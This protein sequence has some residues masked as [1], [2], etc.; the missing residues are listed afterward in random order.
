MK[1][2]RFSILIP[3]RNRAQTLKFAV[4]SCLAQ[5]FDDYEI[6]I[7]DNHSSPET[8]AVVESFASDK[9]RYER[10]DVPLAMSDNWEL[11]V[12]HARGEFVTI[13]GDDDALMRHAL[14]EANRLIEKH[15]PQLIRWAWAYYKWPD[16]SIR[17]DA[18][19]LSFIFTGQVDRVKSAELASVLLQE[20]KRYHE[21]P[22]IYNSFVHRQL[23]DNLRNRTGR[24]F[25]ALSPDVYSGFAFADLAGRF[26]SVSRPLG[27]CGTS[28]HSTGQA[29]VIGCG[30]SANNIGQQFFASCEQSGLVWN[31]S[32][33]RVVKSISAVIAE[34]YAQYRTVLHGSAAFSSAERQSLAA[35]MLDDLWNHPNLSAAERAAAV[36]E[37]REWCAGDAK[38]RSWFAAAA[39]DYAKREP[40]A[41]GS[42]H[43]WHKGVG[44]KCFDIDASDFG[45]ADVDGAA[46][47]IENLLGS[48]SRPVH[49]SRRP[50]L[51]LRSLAQTIL[52]TA[53][54][55][56]S[57]AAS[58]IQRRQ[59][60]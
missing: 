16:Y 23:I 6:V 50:P 19:R 17:A 54:F 55:R 15:H 43:R 3:T 36:E 32:V 37:I 52:P 12:T 26:L 18:S 34:S 20:P 47:L 30:N 53:L 46:A 44:P 42:T 57:G 10:S 48:R 35:A 27:I 9:V 1:R 11:A 33:P 22:M 5:D 24:V 40:A 41:N 49:L 58:N 28:S 31:P 39:A 14:S 38:A 51:T 56:S 7:C 25:S 60:S 2:P 8:R 13:V 29:N 59:A 21:L 4:C 45:V